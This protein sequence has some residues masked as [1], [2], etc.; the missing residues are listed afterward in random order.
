MRLLTRALLG[1]LLVA[2]AIATAQDA[3]PPSPIAKARLLVDAPTVKTGVP[4]TAVVQFTLLPHW[5]IYWQN[6]GDSGI[7]TTF[8]WALPNGISAGDIAWPAPERIDTEGL[9][10]YGYSNAV[11]LTVPLTPSKDAITGDVKLKANWLVCKDICIPESAELSAPLAANPEAATLASATLARIPQPFVGDAVFT[12][13]HDTVTLTLTQ[14]GAWGD[15]SAV[16]FSPVEDGLAANNPPPKVDVVGNDLTLSFT[17]GTADALAVWHGVV[18]YTRDSK[19]VAFNVTAQAADG[20]ASSTSAAPTATTPTGELPREVI[21]PSLLLA[22]ALAFVGGIILNI[23]PCVL[24][25]L[26]L[27]AL[28]L[29]KKAHT[30]RL[31]AAKQGF[32]FT[33]GVIVSFLMIAGLMLALKASGSAIGWGFQLQN[34]FF[35]GFLALIMLLVSANLFGLF[36]LPVL[37]G[38]RATGVD[39]SKLSGSFLTGVLSVLVATPCSAPFMATAIGATL[40]MPTGQALLVFAMLGFGMAAPFLLISLWPAARRLLPKPGAWMHRFKQLLALPMLATALWLVFVLVQLLQPVTFEARDGH[41]AYSPARLEQLRAEG[42]PVLVDAT[43]A[44]CLSCKV[45]E[46]VALKPAEMQQFF[47]DKNVTLMVADWTSYDATITAYLASF[48]RNGVPLYVYYPPQGEPVVLPQ[49]LTP[50]IVRD[51]INGMHN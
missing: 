29:S 13:T 17:R 2:P 21:P 44:W 25:I 22:L 23:M 18:H 37:F 42:K 12:L 33:I 24:P 28:S 7:P 40:S 49:I 48:M 35:V 20:S 30:S 15:I 36:E 5:H 1:L 39:E 41:E 34:P 31:Q 3:I 6:P 10:T 26:A 38:A 46:R 27:K 32:S 16:R 19:E 8:A 9:V 11:T 47:R 45:N 51:A 4:I 14:Q 50:A 43:A